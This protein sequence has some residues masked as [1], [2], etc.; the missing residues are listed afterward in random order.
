MDTAL[1]TEINHYRHEQPVRPVLVV[2]DDE[3]ELSLLA[4]RLGA[5]GYS[6]TTAQSGAQA[7][8]LIRQQSFPVVITDY[9]MPDMDGLQL[10]DRVREQEADRNYLIVWSICGTQADR[11]RSF[12]H[13]ADDHLSKLLPDTELLDRIAVGFST[14]ATRESTRLL[15]MMRRCGSMFGRDRDTD[16]WNISA[17]RLHAE[18]LH[19]AREKAPLSVLMLHVER[20]LMPREKSLLTLTQFICLVSAINSVLRL[21]S[22]FTLPLDAGDGLV[23]LLVVLPR[24]GLPGAQSIRNRLCA[25]LLNSVID[26]P[27]EAFT[28]ES[29]VL[30]DCAIGLAAVETWDTA[31]VANAA[32][33]M[34]NAEHS[35]ERLKLP[36]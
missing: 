2:D 8:A 29:A 19:S 14:V 36:R 33:L 3:L 24:T 21:N 6:V 5:A 17:N 12:S 26:E 4:D 16:G 28:D 1:A 7:C 18:M 15:R 9:K 20:R 32:E 11:D 35:M 34:A 22:D 27:G 13:G 25:A 31:T 10:V 23:R 30:P